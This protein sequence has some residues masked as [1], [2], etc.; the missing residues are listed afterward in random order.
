MCFNQQ[1]SVGAHQNFAGVHYNFAGVH[2]NLHGVHYNLAG[3]PLKYCRM[4]IK[5][6]LGVHVI[7]ILLV[8]I[9]IPKAFS[10]DSPWIPNGFPM[11]SPMDSL[12]IPHSTCI[13]HDFPIKLSP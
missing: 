12:W 2:Y 4:S 9:I 5:I 13:T 10:M 3:C 7:I 8:N 11:D 6:L 1:K